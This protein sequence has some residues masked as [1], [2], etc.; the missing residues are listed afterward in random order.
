MASNQIIR[1]KV[2]QEQYQLIKRKSEIA[3]FLNLSEFLRQVT[4]SYATNQSEMI[5]EYY[6]RIIQDDK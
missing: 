3:G 6:R 1:F 4:L 5:K 2:S